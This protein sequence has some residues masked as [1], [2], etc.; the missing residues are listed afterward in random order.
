MWK[1]LLFGIGM[2][3]IICLVIRSIG[4]REIRKDYERDFAKLEQMVKQYKVNEHNFAVIENKFTAIE[5]YR[6]RD[7]ERLDVLERKFY[8]KFKRILNEL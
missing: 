6:C 5:K 1:L 7:N 3:V 2:S 8:F 4:K